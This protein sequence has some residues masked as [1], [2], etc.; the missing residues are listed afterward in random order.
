MN[1]VAI[2]TEDYERFST[3]RFTKDFVSEA[4]VLRV[5]AGAVGLIVAEH[6]GFSIIFDGNREE[7][8]NNLVASRYVDTQAFGVDHVRDE[9][10]EY[11]N[12]IP[13]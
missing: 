10:F 12:E 11:I 9:Y 5:R 8:R 2:P 4:G 1:Y 13:F 7:N 3:V 6:F